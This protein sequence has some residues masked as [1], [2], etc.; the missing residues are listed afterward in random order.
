M[1]ASSP[2]ER[3][4]DNWMSA[5]RAYRTALDVYRHVL[6]IRVRRDGPVPGTRASI[7]G[8][9]RSMVSRSPSA[10][11]MRL[12]PREREV[13]YLMASG[14]TNQQIAE[15]LVLTRGTVANHVAHI[16]GKLGAGNRTQVAAIVYQTPVELPTL[17]VADN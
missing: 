3:A 6:A 7:N 17:A 5:V 4:I 11:L 9:V 15:M 12:T 10:A 2:R 8:E 14:H 16:L 13:A 1:I